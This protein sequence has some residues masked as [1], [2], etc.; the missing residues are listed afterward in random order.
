MTRPT[1]TTTAT[2][3]AAAPRVVIAHDFAEAFGGA[4]RVVARI[5]SLFPDAP[6]WAI[7]GRREVAR[8]MEV[9]DRF[10]TLL[11]ER[12]R[13]LRHYRA[14]T[15]VYPALVASHRLPAADVLVTSSYAFAH[16]F[17]TR[18]HA[19]QLCYCHSPLRFAWSMTEEYAA[20]MR[21]GRAGAAAL[22]GLALGMRL[23]DRR[24]SRQVARYLANS[25]FV[26]HQLGTLLNRQATV[27]PPPVD[28]DLFRPRGVPDDY[29][30]LCGRLIAYKRPEL[31]VEAFRGLSRRL[32]VAGEGPALAQLRRMAS[33]N[34]EFTGPLEDQDLVSL[35]QRCAG[36]IFPGRDDAGL[37]PVEVMACGRPVLAFGSG[38][39]LETVVPGLTGEF[40][41]RQD[42]ECLRS[43][44]RSF[45]PDAYDSAEIRT[46][47]ERWETKRF[48]AEL[49]AAVTALAARHL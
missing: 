40:F 36:A 21:G 1:S 42:P 38:G 8:K 16:G 7:L 41:D 34:V 49:S 30:L 12:H 47:A 15:P 33:P 45:D 2:E 37:L 10:F 27:V 31:A 48:D 20:L 26:A 9:E 39:A 5:A 25:R 24:A 11:P 32:V 22:S 14:L 23:I 3:P 13:L 28:C 29:Y 17:R 18:N 46:H 44:I 4:E 19:P 6:V 43:A 35:M